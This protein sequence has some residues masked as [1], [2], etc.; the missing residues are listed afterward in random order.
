MNAKCQD[1]TSISAPC[2][3]EWTTKK[4][5]YKCVRTIA[6]ETGETFGRTLLPFALI[7][8]VLNISKLHAV[9]VCWFL[10]FHSIS[11]RFI[12]IT[13]AAATRRFLLCQCCCCCCFFRLV[14]LVCINILLRF[15]F[16]VPLSLSLSRAPVSG[17]VFCLLL[18]SFARFVRCSY[19][20]YCVFTYSF[21]TIRFIIE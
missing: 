8:I 12:I 17:C 21:C 10:S 11:F 16:S 20:N 4:G 6:D 18:N 9:L 5:T 3:A 19:C 1:T 7:I 15:G 2:R 13:A 14:S